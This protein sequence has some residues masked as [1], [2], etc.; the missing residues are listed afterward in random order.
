MTFHGRNAFYWFVVLYRSRHGHAH[1]TNDNDTARVFRV[2]TVVGAPKSCYHLPPET[3]PGRDTDNTNVTTK[4]WNSIIKF[5]EIIENQ[6][7]YY[8]FVLFV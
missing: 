8:N 7:L 5:I 3:V 6:L 1:D 4:I 2:I